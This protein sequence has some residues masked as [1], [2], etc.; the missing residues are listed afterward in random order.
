MQVGRGSASGL[1]DDKVSGDE[2]KFVVGTWIQ[3]R[4]MA[5]RVPVSCS[6]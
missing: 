1:R 2:E 4:G 5:L 6:V 3:V